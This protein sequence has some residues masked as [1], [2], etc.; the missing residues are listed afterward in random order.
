MRC[1]WTCALP[2]SF[3]HKLSACLSELILAKP[4]GIRKYSFVGSLSSLGGKNHRECLNCT[5]LP[6]RPHPALLLELSLS[7]LCISSVSSIFFLPA[8]DI[9][10]AASHTPLHVDCGLQVSFHQT[11]ALNCH[12]EVRHGGGGLTAVS[13]ITCQESGSR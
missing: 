11:R 5:H 8:K 4:S 1:M 13:R 9:T 12:L 10:S 2:S 3:P 7:S 6:A